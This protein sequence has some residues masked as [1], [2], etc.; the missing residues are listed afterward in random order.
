MDD[1]ADLVTIG[2]I[3]KPFGVRGDVK[4]RSLSDVPGRFEGLQGVTL[5]SAS[6]RHLTTAVTHVRGSGASYVVGFE[7]FSSPEDTTAF[8]GGW[9]MIPR[10]DLPL[11]PTG[12]YYESDLIGLKVVSENGAGLGVLEE[13]LN[14]GEQHIFVVRGDR[15]E[16]L[17][18]A[19]KEIVEVDLPSRI[20]RVRA[21]VEGLFH[22]QREGVGCDVKS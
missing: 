21:E 1:L 20:M 6:G 12:Q 2:Q 9:V 4:V 3:V 10:S 11:L 7:A 16:L 17:L 5:V 15:G 19:S 14:G 8:R 13:I 22:G 18:P